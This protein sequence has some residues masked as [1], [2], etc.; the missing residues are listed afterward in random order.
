MN[1]SNNFSGQPIIKQLLK[2]LPS[3][4]ISRTVSQHN[5]DRYYNRFKTYVSFP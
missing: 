1:K 2:L 4:I 3:A 5:S